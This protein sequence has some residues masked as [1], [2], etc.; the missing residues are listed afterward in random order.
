VLPGRYKETGMAQIVN[1]SEYRRQSAVQSGFRM[2]NRRFNKNFDRRT[3][4][5]DFGPAI[6]CLLSEP[7]ESSTV[8]YYA[9]ILGF[10]GHGDTADF[11]A[12]DRRTQMQVVDIHLFLADQVRFEMMR[13]MGWLA[14]FGATQYPLFDM[15]R[16][17]EAI[18]ILCWQDPPVLAPMHPSHKAYEGLIDRDRQVFIR[19]MMPS[20]VDQ[21]KQAFPGWEKEC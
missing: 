19:R 16:Q 14:R 6:L 13:R 7:T 10:L 9:L 18:R 2:L 20:V 21:F 12:M 5:N 17:F 15:V 11:D 1:L 4:L 3:R 8:F